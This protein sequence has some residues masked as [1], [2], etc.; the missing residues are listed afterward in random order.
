MQNIDPQTWSFKYNMHNWYKQSLAIDPDFGDAYYNM[1]CVYALQG[2]KALALRYLS[3][4]TPGESATAMGLSGPTMA[5]VVQQMLEP[6]LRPDPFVMIALR[7][8]LKILLQLLD[9]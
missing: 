9:D 5:V 3:G 7:A 1:A 4:L 6:L 8:D 2:Q